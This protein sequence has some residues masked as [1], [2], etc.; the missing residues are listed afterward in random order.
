MSAKEKRLRE[1]ME[2]G[3][4]LYEEICAKCETNYDPN[5]GGCDTCDARILHRKLTKKIQ[6]QLDVLVANES[7]RK[8]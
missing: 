1:I 6:R 4:K 7:K 8:S 2:I 5:I 3:D